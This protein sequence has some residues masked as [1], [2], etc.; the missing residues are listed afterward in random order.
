LS[1]ITSLRRA[2]LVERDAVAHEV[3]MDVA[4]PPP[5]V[6]LQREERALALRLAQGIDERAGGVG[7][8]SSGHARLLDREEPG[9]HAAAGG[10]ALEGLGEQ[11]FAGLHVL[12]QL[13]RQFRLTGARRD[14]C[15]L[16]HLEAGRRARHRRHP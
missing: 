7:D 12:L 13:R 11:R 4:P 1:R 15:A 10:D 6:G 3:G 16:S 2:H 8:L 9:R 5:H 14:E